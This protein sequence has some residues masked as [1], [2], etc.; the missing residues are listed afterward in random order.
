MAKVADERTPIP[1]SAA[2]LKLSFWV[3]ARYSFGCGFWSG[4]GSTRR[5]G[6]FQNLPSQENSSD[7]QILG[8]I[9]IDSSH[10]AR[11]SRGSTPS[12]V[13]S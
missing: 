5:G 1:L 11:V 8:S 4:F 10:M 2:T 13:S 3:Q 12:P 7:C 6:T 9:V